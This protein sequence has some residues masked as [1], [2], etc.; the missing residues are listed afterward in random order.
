MSEPAIK[1][2]TKKFSMKNHFGDQNFDVPTWPGPE[3]SPASPDV[4]LEFFPFGGFL[5]SFEGS[6]QPHAD[7]EAQPPE[8]EDQ[9]WE[10]HNVEDKVFV[11]LRPIGQFGAI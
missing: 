4:D 9:R 8:E 11:H 2:F 5:C 6:L 3:S 1:R 7:M 10:K